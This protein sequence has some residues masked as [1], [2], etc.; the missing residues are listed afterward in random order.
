MW[1]M[2]EFQS[3]LDNLVSMI[4]KTQKFK[5]GLEARSNGLCL[6]PQQMGVWGRRIAIGLRS[7]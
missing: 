4:L 2:S 5:K 3:S 7:S 6:E 1:A